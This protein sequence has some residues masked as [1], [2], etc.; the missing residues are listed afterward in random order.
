MH[1]GL[2]SKRLSELARTSNRTT[3]TNILDKVINLLDGTKE[4][5]YKKNLISGIKALS[6]TQYTKFIS[7]ILDGGFFPIIVPP[8]KS[9]KYDAILDA[10]KFLDL[11]PRYHLELKKYNIKKTKFPVALG[12]ISVMKLE[13]MG[14]K[15]LH[16]RSTG[17]YN[18]KTFSPTQGKKY[19]GGQKIGEYD[20]YSLLAW[21][22]KI[23]IDELFGPLSAD[24]KAKNEIITQII[25]T[26]KANFIESKIN[27]TKD[28]FNA[29]M[30]AIHLT[31]ERRHL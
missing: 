12:Y 23:V 31:G 14:E 16:V 27:P 4:K 2:I 5:T 25:Q 11:K 18:A 17:P 3:Y 1:V 30:M 6:E 15:G 7:E 9:P 21:D 29:Y 19:D 22:A 13:H 10:L 28:L 8:F 24:H 26:G 20:M